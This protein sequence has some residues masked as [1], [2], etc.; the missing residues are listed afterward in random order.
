MAMDYDYDVALLQQKNDKIR[1]VLP[2]EGVPAY[3]EGFTAVKNTSQIEVIQAFF[4]FLAQPPQYADFVNTTGTAYVEQAATPLIAK[5]ISQN[6]ILAPTPEVL[7]KIEFDKYLGPAGTALWKPDVDR[8][9]GGI[10]DM[11]ADITPGGIFPDYELVDHRRTKRSLSE[12]Q[13]DDPMVLMLARGHHCAEEHQQHL[14]LA[15]CYPQ[16]AVANTQVVTIATDADHELLE[17][18]ASVGAHWPFLSDP[19]RIIQKDLEIQE[20]TQP[21]FDSMI[22]HTIVLKPGLAISTIYNGYWFWGRPSMRT[23]AATC[24][25]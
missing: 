18:R 5:T 8:Y 2:D 9:Q 12:L 6:P 24:A 7:S 13:G 3:L 15:R 23:C 17:F 20:Y 16:I 4:N 25:R 22:P 11:R 21:E 1:W 14:E 19:Q 10:V